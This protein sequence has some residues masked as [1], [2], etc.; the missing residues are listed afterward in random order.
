MR[1]I[2]LIIIT[3]LLLGLVY[4]CVAKGLTIGPVQVLSMQQIEEQSQDLKAKIE[5]VNMK[6]DVEY[7]NRISQLKNASRSMQQAKD[8]Y[9]R[10]TNLSSDEAII[11][12]KTEK[13][14]AIE[15]LWAKIGTHARNE[16]INLKLEIAAS[17][18]G[19]NNVNDLKFTVEGTYIAITNFIYAIENDSALDFRIQNFKLLP[20]KEEILQ[21][22]FSVSNI[23][24]QGNN[25]NKNISAQNV[26]QQSAEEDTDEAQ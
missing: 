6:I 26:E 9:L 5:E 4:T 2:L 17:N 20:Y 14:Y 13:S 24:V 25:L 16:G 10:Y 22:T 8:E 7:P 1:K 11:A 18:T 19:A 12:A 21:G 3:V 23:S 15:F